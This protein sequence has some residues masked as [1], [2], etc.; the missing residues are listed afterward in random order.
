L[1]ERRRL[2]AERLRGQYAATFNTLS[3][4]VVLGDFF[5]RYGFDAEGVER[6]SC[7]AGEGHVDAARRDGQKE[8]VRY[9][10]RMCGARCV[11]P[12]VVFSESQQQ[13]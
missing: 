13:Q 7:I 4:H 2:G 6:P 11:L 8:V 9:V 10:L 5:A 3:G 12:E 1:A